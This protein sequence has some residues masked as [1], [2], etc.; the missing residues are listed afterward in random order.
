MSS[1]ECVVSFS[2]DYEVIF[3]HHNTLS[4]EALLSFTVSTTNVA[5]LN[6]MTL[7]D[8]LQTKL[9]GY[10]LNL[11]FIPKS[12]CFTNALIISLV[13]R[14]IMN[15]DETGSFRAKT[16]CVDLKGRFHN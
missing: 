12:R 15:L 3:R 2:F 14:P 6:K 9:S 4:Q 16:N 7:S 5:V 8:T 1:A 11:F 10:L 13:E